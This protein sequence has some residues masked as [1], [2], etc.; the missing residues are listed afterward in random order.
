M[1]VLFSELTLISLPGQNGKPLSLQNLSEQEIRQVK[2]AFNICLTFCHC[3]MM[4]MLPG[5]HICLTPVCVFK[6]QK[7]KWWEFYLAHT[8]LWLFSNV[9]KGNDEMSYLAH[10]TGCGNRQASVNQVS[11]WGNYH[12]DDWTPWLDSHYHIIIITNINHYHC[13][14]CPLWMF[15]FTW[16]LKC[17]FTWALECTF[18]WTL[19]CT[20]TWAFK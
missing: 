15:T 3:A 19:K 9:K 17:T 20:F 14:H 11:F 16:A 13:Q 8:F 4:R 10:T 12:N 6:C 2:T 18:T 1:S 5:P 7:R